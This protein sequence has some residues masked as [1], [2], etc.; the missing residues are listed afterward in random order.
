[1]PVLALAPDVLSV[2]VTPLALIEVEIVL[3]AAIVK[4]LVSIKT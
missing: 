3:P 4:L 1:M 2:Q